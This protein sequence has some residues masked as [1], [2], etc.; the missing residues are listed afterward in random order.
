MQI[1][2]WNQ[3]I[4]E[5]LGVPDN[6]VDSAT[7]IYQAIIDSLEN[8]DNSFT[9]GSITYLKQSTNPGNKINIEKD[10]SLDFSISELKFSDIKFDMTIHVNDNITSCDVASWAVAVSHEDDSNYKVVY[11]KSNAG[12][13]YLKVDF[14]VRSDESF[15]DLKNH[16]LDKRSNTIGVLSH[17]LK[18]VY[19]KYMIGRH[20]LSDIIEYQ[21]FAKT[22][23][24]FEELDLFFYYLYLTSQEENLVRPSE[25]AGQIISSGITKSEF[26]KFIE[27][28]KV[29]SDMIKI[30]N[31]SYKGLKDNL[32]NNIGNIRK[33]FHDIPE[34]ESDKDVIDVV[35]KISYDALMEK[36]SDIIEK[37]LD[38]NNAAKLL[39]GKI[40]K[41]D[42]D[43][44]NEYLK[45]KSFKSYDDFFN[46]WE[47]KLKFEANK[48]I[49]K[50]SKLYD[51][52]KDN[53]INPLMAKIND[54][55]DG[56]CI[57]NP[58]LYREVV[59]GSKVGKIDYKK[60]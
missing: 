39:T 42:I 37:Y 43:F 52:C 55:I 29:Y 41:E 32:K 6:I 47:K 53:N 19:D 18:H 21:S 7:K 49:K 34:S 40:K 17:E 10:F 51:M 14:V 60:I 50:I 45:S 9:F 8:Y 56:K 46:Y 4:I 13:I 20:L 16:L 15:Q 30:R 12:S 11:N 38:L 33:M 2:S 3:F 31:W 58:K 25:I 23:T 59:L 5:R 26:K 27:E 1:K 48:V 44:Y 35:L 57:V 54:R 22:S 28:T 36:S 24:G